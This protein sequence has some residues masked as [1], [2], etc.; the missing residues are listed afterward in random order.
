MVESTLHSAVSTLCADALSPS[1]LPLSIFLL[2]HFQFNSQLKILTHPQNK[3]LGE[4]SGKRGQK[5]LAVSLA[6]TGPICD[7]SLA[8]TA[9]IWAWSRSIAKAS[10]G[11]R[12]PSMEDEA[13]T[14]RNW[15]T[16]EE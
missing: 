5:N 15:V 3:I 10:P 2:L 4:V 7:V 16:T 13:V 12:Q 9:P 8:V 11:F 1:G 6:V 14:A